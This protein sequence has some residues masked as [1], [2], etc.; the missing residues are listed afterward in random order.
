MNVSRRRP[1]SVQHWTL[2]RWRA[3]LPSNGSWRWYLLLLLLLSHR[4]DSDVTDAAI[5]CSPSARYYSAVSV[6]SPAADHIQVGSSEVRSMS[7]RFTCKVE[8]RN[9]SAVELY[10]HLPSRCWS[11]HSLAQTSRHSFQCSAPSVWNSLPPTIRKT[12]C[13][14]LN[15]ELKLFLFNPGF[16][17]HWSHLRPVP[18]KL[19]P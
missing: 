17:E 14:F 2:C 9:L 19:R 15:P 3:V 11:N 5:C 13:P 1:T 12:L 8:S 16:T 4:G 18:L 10:V 6:A 7:I